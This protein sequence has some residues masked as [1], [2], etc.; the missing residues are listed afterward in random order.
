MS[1]LI[2]FSGIYSGVIGK[3]L[4]SDSTLNNMRKSELIELLHISENNYKALAGFY[5]VSV[6]NSKCNSCPL[7]KNA[8]NVDQVV[9][10]LKAN[11]CFYEYEDGYLRIAVALKDAIEIVRKGGKNVD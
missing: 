3:K 6:D 5:S 10:E 2:D 4:P 8:Y 7:G 1:R 11:S 9:E